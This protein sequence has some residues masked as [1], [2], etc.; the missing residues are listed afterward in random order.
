MFVKEELAILSFFEFFKE[1]GAKF[2]PLTFAQFRNTF[3]HGF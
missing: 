1:L 2:F 3:F